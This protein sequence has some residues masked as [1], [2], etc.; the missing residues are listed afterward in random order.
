MKTKLLV[1]GAGGYIGSVATYLFLEKGYEVVAIDNYATGYEAPLK[2]LQ[3][4]FGEK[5][6]R[7][8]NVD[9]K[10]DISEVFK[11]EK[12]IEAAVHY[13][14]HCLVN[15]SMEN[16]MKYFSNNVGGSQ[17]LISTLLR[18]DI[19]KMVFSST[20]AVYGEA[21]YV[22]VDERHPTKPMNPYGE[23]KRMV[24]KMMEW[25]S[26]LSGLSFVILRYFNVCGA[27]DDGAIG[28]SKHPSVLLVQNAVRGA[29][30]IEPFHLTCPR[31]KTPDGTPI[32][33]Y[34]NVVDLNIAHLKA[35][36]YLRNNG[37]SQTINL[38]TGT[39]NSVLEIVNA[40]QE[41][42]GKKFELTRAEP[43]KGEY[44]TMFASI[45]KAGDVLGWK[46]ERSLQ[47]TIESLVSWYTAHPHGWE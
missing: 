18:N 38:G 37:Q 8:Y 26:A 29:L 6:L 44:A 41:V 3:Q 9:L 31:V 1:T 40:V 5:A 30:G 47:K 10:E 21:E 23:S 34:V 45:K 11:K 28:D 17:N 19:K 27:S 43:R 2:L 20:C 24:E 46:P 22:P 33:D 13:A 7:Y 4:K 14:A 32:R 36:E 12:N 35:L 42:T 16:P 15:E 39:G 25:Y